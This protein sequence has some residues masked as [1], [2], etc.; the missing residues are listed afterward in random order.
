M[1][2]F[3]VIDKGMIT[4]CVRYI[5]NCLPGWFIVQSIRHD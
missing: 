3:K 2:S 5:T 4:I 1:D